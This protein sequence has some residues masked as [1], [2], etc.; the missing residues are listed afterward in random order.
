MQTATGPCMW[1]ACRDWG[2]NQD[3]GLVDGNCKGI[4]IGE[5]PWKAPRQVGLC[6]CPPNFKSLYGSFKW[7]Q[8]CMLSDDLNT[9]SLSQS[10]ALETDFGGEVGKQN[11]HSKN[12]V[13]DKEPLI[14][15]GSSCINQW[16][17]LLDDLLQ[18]QSKI[19]YLMRP[20]YWMIEPIFIGLCM[21]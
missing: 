13:G 9:M 15:E 5:L 14:V 11:V 19:Y 17:C 1:R 18:H 20:Q 4:N 6:T 7:T 12:G 16:S 10:C 2:K 8:S 21:W 3:T